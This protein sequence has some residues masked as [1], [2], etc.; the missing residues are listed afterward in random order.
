MEPSDDAEHCRGGEGR[1]FASNSAARARR[2]A[3]MNS[4]VRTSRSSVV[5][6]GW[7][8]DAVGSCECAHDTAKHAARS[9]NERLDPRLDGKR[10][11]EE[12]GRCDQ[13]VKNRNPRDHPA[14]AVPRPC[15]ESILRVALFTEA[16]L[17]RKPLCAHAACDEARKDEDEWPEGFY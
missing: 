16:G 13:E 2:H 7:T 1:G 11:E 15:L 8:S 12:N 4:K 9:L 5:I 10:R 17:E 6:L 3:A 14:Q